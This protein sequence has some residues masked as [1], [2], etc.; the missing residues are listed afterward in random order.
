M[1]RTS[2]VYSETCTTWLTG[3]DHTSPDRKCAS[4]AY[5]EHRNSAPAGRN[6]AHEFRQILQT[7]HVL[8]HWPALPLTET[9]VKRVR[10]YLVAY[11]VRHAHD[12]KEAF[13]FAG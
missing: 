9:Q 7:P 13:E 8:T 3:K 2:G 12:P 11:A 1:L 10:W 6:L 4:I 5:W